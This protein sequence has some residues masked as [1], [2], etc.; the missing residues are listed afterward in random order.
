[1]PFW[2]LASLWLLLSGC[3]LMTLPSRQQPS[4]RHGQMD[5][6]TWDFVSQGNVSLQGEWIF[7]PHALMDPASFDIQSVP[8]TLTIPGSPNQGPLYHQ[9]ESIG[10]GTF[11]SRLLLPTA[12]SSQDLRLRLWMVQSAYTLFIKNNQSGAVQKLI[13]NGRVGKTRDETIGEVSER[14][15]LLPAAMLDGG[16]V[17]LIMHASAYYTNLGI[18]AAPRLGQGQQIYREEIFKQME[19]A[20]I[21]GGFFL[22]AL[23]SFALYLGR[24]RSQLDLW[25][26]IFAVTLLFRYVGTEMFLFWFFEGVAW[27][28]PI[29][30]TLNYWGSQFACVVVAIMFAAMHP[31]PALRYTRN[32][33]I[34]L[35]IAGLLA[36]VTVGFDWMV[37]NVIQLCFLGLLLNALA[38]AG[39][40]A[41]LTMKKAKDMDLAALGIT[42]LALAGLNDYLVFFKN[43]QGIFLV[44]YAILFFAFTQSLM[45]GRRFNRT[46]QRNEE[47][48][49]EISEKERARTVFFH[50][51]S[52]ELRTP[53]NGIIG[54]L[55]L[56]SDDRYG[57]QT[58]QSREQLL[59][60]I[61]LAES[62]K[63][64]VNTILDLAKSKKGNLTLENSMISLDELYAEACDLAEG[65]LLKRVDSR[66]EAERTWKKDDDHFVG[67]RE[68]IATIM[69]NLLGNAFKFADPQRSNYVKMMMQREADRLVLTISDSGIGIPKDQ[70]E[71]IFEEFHQ[72]AD[73]AR[74]N[75]EGS[76]LGLSMVRDL[77]ELMG[78]TVDVQSE[79]GRGS[80]FKVVIP[81]QSQVHVKQARE[82]IPTLAL[83]L[84]TL[85]TQ[86]TAPVRS[87]ASRIHQG[88]SQRILVVDDNEI[89]CEVIQHMLENQGYEVLVA[90]G[91]QEALVKMRTELPDLVLLDMMMPQVSGEDV[92]KA[93][94]HDQLLQDTPV[95]LVT[96]RASEDDRLFGLSLGADDYL[97]KP[98]HQDELLMRVRNLLHR[99]E[100][101]RR[102]S[103]L[104]ERDR[105][106]QLGELLGELSHELKNIFQFSDLNQRIDRR[107]LAQLLRRL[108]LTG[109]G[110][111]RAA[112]V[113]AD[114]DIGESQEHG[115]DGLSFASLKQ[116]EDPILRS[117]R[118]RLAHVPMPQADKQVIWQSMQQLSDEDRLYCDH[119]LT[120]VRSFVLLRDQSRYARDLIMDILEFN[121]TQEG[122]T[123]CELVRTVE[124]VLKLSRPRLA[125][126]RIRVEL[127]LVS[128]NV[129]ISAGALM[130]ILFNLF[131]NACDAMQ[132][133]PSGERWIQLNADVADENVMIHVINAGP[134][135]P[136]TIAR[137][138][139]ERGFTSKGGQG[140]GLGLSIVWRLLQ[141]V[142][143]RIELDAKAK[144]PTFIITLKTKR[145]DPV[146]RARVS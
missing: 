13:E 90:Y 126:Q 45:T 105:L 106:A 48:L 51:T 53:L 130:Q 31:L 146:E 64:Q 8:G 38:L 2:F 108:P 74:R 77:I 42:V 33:S 72:V 66:F 25:S 21:M 80:T 9:R 104:E 144:S 113:L 56:L 63:N 12:E 117:L 82:E 127:S 40:I 50:N 16:D 34:A 78:G 81:E 23:Y 6:Q 30:I 139:F 111:S 54:F 119:Q 27:V 17:T 92:I 99:L 5:L 141:R 62:L 123:S 93:M 91:G 103:Q 84:A 109:P 114:G 94:K 67:D 79:T 29:S 11:A 18:L 1:M 43:M 86:V 135:I 61:R 10:Y 133:L 76:G 120:L 69:R 122:E 20:L 59:K 68:K 4:L 140:S 110:W 129:Q 14:I 87:P 60:C 41:Y 145:S 47:L 83:P 112:D 128:L 143:G 3:Q 107:M 71:A 49:L 19:R 100:I 70:L 65:L 32:A 22:V 36:V 138:I 37:Q 24:R 98:I 115:L 88:F 97:A 75:Y 116:S 15:I 142:H 137:S 26:A 132:S 118:M 102:M 73:D 96:A 52:H 28:E 57:P 55:Q 125:R 121:R 58:P 44:Q 95:I 124:A 85:P 7:Q 136:E 89:N 46:F 35:N 101:N 39:I 131:S 134:P